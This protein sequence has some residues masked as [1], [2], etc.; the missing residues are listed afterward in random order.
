[1]VRRPGVFV[2]NDSVGVSGE[3]ETR[4]QMRKKGAAEKGPRKHAYSG[5]HTKFQRPGR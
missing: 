3:G 5:F 4:G 1:M 2:I